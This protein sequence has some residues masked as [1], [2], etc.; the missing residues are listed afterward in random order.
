[1]RLLEG[2]DQEL[3]VVGQPIVLGL[4]V[5]GHAVA[6]LACLLDVDALLKVDLLRAVHLRP[7]TVLRADHAEE[8]AL[9]RSAGG[10]AGQ[11]AES[12]ADCGAFAGVCGGVEGPTP[13]VRQELEILRHSGRPAAY[14]ALREG[15]LEALE[16]RQRGLALRHEAAGFLQELPGAAE[17]ALGDRQRADARHHVLDLLVSHPPGRGASVRCPGQH[18]VDRVVDLADEIGALLG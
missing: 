16:V 8:C 4:L 1:M 6:P 10:I 14:A 9:H 12:G 11:D 7:L 18:P 5:V 17:S 15:A 3:L 13:G 2:R